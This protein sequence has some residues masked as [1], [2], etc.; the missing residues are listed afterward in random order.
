MLL[1]VQGNNLVILCIGITIIAL[2]FSIYIIVD[3]LF[4]KKEDVKRNDIKDDNVNTDSSIRIQEDDGIRYIEEDSETEKT[5]AKLELE[6]IKEK[7]L[8]EEMN[9]QDKENITTLEDNNI[10]IA[11]EKNINDKSEEMT[12]N[13]DKVQDIEPNAEANI[14][15]VINEENGMVNDTVKSVKSTIREDVKT[16]DEREKI[17]REKL[18]NSFNINGSVDSKSLYKNISINEYDTDEET[19]IISYEELKNAASF[20]YTDEEMDKY[21]DEKDAI[22]SISELEKLYKEVEEI[23]K[24]KTIE[25]MDIEYKSV[26][27]LPSI[28]DSNIFQN[29]PVISPVY[30]IS[31]DNDNIEI[32]SRDLERLND[33]IKKTNEFLK[34]LKDLKKKLQ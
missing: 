29:S 15:S 16:I 6:K 19:A 18:K 4:R 20:G 31:S 1:S 5:N 7:L 8:L 17:I 26:K 33:E 24:E 25:K 22:I 11:E 30:G 28:K 14:E 2:F 27:D 12:L 13:V 10:I 3:L 21:V 32:Q 23:N 34:A 9:N